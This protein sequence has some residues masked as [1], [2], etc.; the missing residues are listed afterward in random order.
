MDQKEKELRAK[1]A[2]DIRADLVCCDMYDQ[3][4][5]VA[6]EY[7]ARG[8]QLWNPTVEIWDYNDHQ[9]CHWGECA[10]RIAEEGPE[11]EDL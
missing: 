3:V 6:A 5:K 9:I 4:Q 10:A 2:Y 1:I 11:N 8:Q 7:R